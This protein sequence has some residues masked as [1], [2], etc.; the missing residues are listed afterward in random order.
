MLVL[1]YKINNEYSKDDTVLFFTERGI[2]E[3]LFGAAALLGAATLSPYDAFNFSYGSLWPWLYY[4]FL[5]WLQRAAHWQL[6][7]SS[8][9]LTSG[10]DILSQGG[11]SWS[12]S[13][14]LLPDSCL[15][16]CLLLHKCWRMCML[17][18]SICSPRGTLFLCLQVKSFRGFT[19]QPIHSPRAKGSIYPILDF[20]C[21][22]VSLWN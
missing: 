9:M 7:M 5:L 1:V 4:C 16:I 14:S 15:L 22:K 6:L 2:L 8:S 18:F 12:F 21:H 20:N 19:F 11:T 3:C 17:L 10:S 13:F